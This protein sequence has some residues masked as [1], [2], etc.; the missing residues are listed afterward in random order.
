MNFFKEIGKAVDKLNLIGMA[1]HPA[2]LL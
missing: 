2:N 1:T